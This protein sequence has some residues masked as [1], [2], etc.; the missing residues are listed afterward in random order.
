MVFGIGNIPIGIKGLTNSLQLQWDQV[1]GH[2]Q[3]MVLETLEGVDM[4]HGTDVLEKFQVQ[5][6][7]KKHSA[8][9]SIRDDPSV[10]IV[11]E[12]NC[13]IPAGKSRVF[14]LKNSLA[15][16]TL[17]EPSDRLPEGMIGLPTLSEGNKVAIQLDNLSGEDIILNAKWGIGRLYPVEI[18]AG[19]P[20]R[21][22]PE[23]PSSL[24]EAQKRDLNK[25]L[26]QY[27]DVFYQTGNPIS[28]TPLVCIS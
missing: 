7:T 15:G 14:F 3:L 28:S 8:R 19:P 18:T 24:D 22:L 2:C 21:H 1:E 6:D 25:F 17:F 23:I 27:K 26:G 4:I 11:L 12:E 9:P 13:K 20:S 16:L 5:I 10:A